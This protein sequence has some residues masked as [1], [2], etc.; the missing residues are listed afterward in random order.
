MGRGRGGLGTL[1]P[2]FGQ[3]FTEGACWAHHTMLLLV[4][5]HLLGTEL[6]L[7]TALTIGSSVVREVIG[8]MVNTV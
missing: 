2:E 1:M 3:N 6:L 7:E 4:F 5:L 8:S